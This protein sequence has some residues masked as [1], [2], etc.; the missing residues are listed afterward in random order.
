MTPAALAVLAEYHA[1]AGFEAPLRALWVHDA[2]LSAS[3]K[4]G[5]SLEAPLWGA[6]WLLRDDRKV[7]LLALGGAELVRAD[8]VGVSDP[9]AAERRA[10][11]A[12]RSG[13]DVGA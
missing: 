8:F 12:R 3:V 7:A 1:R 6:L 4:T 9:S 10:P 2:L 13:R 5:R 11:A